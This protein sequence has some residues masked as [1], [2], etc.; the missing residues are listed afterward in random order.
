MDIISKRK[1][2]FILSIAII[3]VGLVT[4]AVNGLNLGIDFAG[5]TLIQIDLG[6]QIAVE[7]IREIT[8]GQN[9]TANIVH[10]GEE[11]HEVII[12]TTEDLNNEQRKSLKAKF[13]EK[14]NLD[15]EAFMQSK[16]ISPSIGD[17]IKRK[18]LISVAIATA[19]MLL[20]IT[21]RFQFAFGISAIIALVHDVLIA[22]AVY[23]IFRIP[24]NT[25]FVA[26][27]LTIVGYSINDTI[28]V[29]DRIRENL[30]YVRKEGYENVINMS[31]SQT[32]VR[33]I[34]TSFT[35]L[36]AITSLYIFGVEA[37]KDFALP[38]IVGVLVGTYSSIF[39]ASPV[40]FMLKTRGKN[41]N[42]SNP[43]KA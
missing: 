30:R 20:Y 10:A 11:N 43:R 9:L 25:S 1:I 15:E 32:I 34:N 17:E 35:T 38:L 39:V 14:Y 33:S 36:L 4:M 18:A 12:K 5:G 13:K 31:I 23:A 28:V 6:K 2:F 37:I 41:K 16:Q 8:D 21:F 22:L 29:F 24:V 42:G 19:G 3:L 27:I 7:E 26:A 40:W